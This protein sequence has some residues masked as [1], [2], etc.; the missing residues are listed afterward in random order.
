MIKDAKYKE[1]DG[2]GGV[3]V[4]KR[5]IDKKKKEI[6]G[7]KNIKRKSNNKKE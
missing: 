4:N 7:E 2:G 6:K 5:K 1:N 3:S